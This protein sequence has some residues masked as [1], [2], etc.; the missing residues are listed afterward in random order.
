MLTLMNLFALIH[1]AEPHWKWALAAG[2]GI[3]AA[4]GDIVTPPEAVWE[5][6]TWKGILVAV[7][8]FLFKLLLSQQ[9][10]HKAENLEREKS[11]ES[12]MKE[13]KESL[14]KVTESN[15]KLVTVTEEQTGFFKAVTRDLVKERL[16]GKK[17]ARETRDLP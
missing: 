17:E 15:Q 7:I 8:I 3:I 2:A 10:E 6:R 4:V 12:S 14:E 9:K 16:V 1:H 5:D 11:I 13:L